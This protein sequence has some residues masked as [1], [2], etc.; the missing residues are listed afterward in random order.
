MAADPLALL[1]EARAGH[2]PPP[3]VAEAFPEV[4][5]GPLPWV[6]ADPLPLLPR[7]AEALPAALLEVL[8]GPA[9]VVVSDAGSQ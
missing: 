4:P 7:A 5:S 3:W 8:K 2:L 6:E 9:V 1:R